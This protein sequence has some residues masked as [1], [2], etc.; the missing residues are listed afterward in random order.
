[1]KFDQLRK[2]NDIELV[3]ATESVVKSEREILL[4]VLHHLRETDRRKL[5]PALKYKSLFEY[6]VQ[7]LGYSEDQAFHRI[8]AMR[9]LKSFSPEVVD[10]R[11]PNMKFAELLDILLD[12]GIQEFDPGKKIVRS[13]Q[14]K[15]SMPKVM[16]C[17]EI[18]VTESLKPD[19]LNDTQ[20][21][22]VQNAITN[23]KSPA[24]SWVKLLNHDIKNSNSCQ[25]P[26]FIPADLRRAIWKRDQS[27]C[28]NC[29]SQFALEL[30]HIIPIALG[31]ESDAGNLRL[32]C[33]PC[34]QRAGWK[35]L[36]A[37]MMSSKSRHHS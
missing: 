31:G 13:Y 12:L 17:S 2:L 16:T 22:T 8:S 29:K 19:R 24:A 25:N 6:V 37:M 5:Y 3:A 20:K 34:N 11:Y 26:R 33:R 1:M 32:T 28:V 35:K 10:H 4:S 15:D 9:M 36:G 7:K 21:K 30:D 18:Q 14:K 23:E 27:C